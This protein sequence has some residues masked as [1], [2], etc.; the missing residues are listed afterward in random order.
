[1]KVSEKST[2]IALIG[3]L[4]ALIIVL[5]LFAELLRI[6]GMP[7]SLA[8]G[9]I[10]VFTIAQ[11]NGY[12]YG[13][14]AGFIFGM[15]SLVIA[16]IGTAA[17]PMFAVVINPLVSVVPR[18]LSGMVCG[19]IFTAM[20]RNNTSKNKK[21][22]YLS[23]T[24]ATLGGVLTNTFLFLGMFFAFAHGKIYNE[25]TINFKWLITSVV[26]LNTIIELCVF[27]ITVPAIVNAL[28]SAKKNNF[29]TNG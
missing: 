26:A 8:L 16:V 1:M 12:K 24:I 20:N 21:K 3:M 18:I 19:L 6:L 15:V 28:F 13:M 10:P 22:R 11:T 9:I 2:K 7:I 27:A 17:N 23:S 4:C 25:I 5:Q 14:L 29:T